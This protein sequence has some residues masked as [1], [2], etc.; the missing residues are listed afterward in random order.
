MKKRGGERRGEAEA[1]EQ[2]VTG[3]GGSGKRAATWSSFL[4]E[5]MSSAVLSTYLVWRSGVN[6]RCEETVWRGGG[7]RGRVGPS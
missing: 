4:C 5:R 2:H 7:E 3:L 6:R 1:E